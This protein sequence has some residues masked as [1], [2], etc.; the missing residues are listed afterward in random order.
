MRQFIW[1]V[2]ARKKLLRKESKQ[3]QEQRQRIGRQLELLQQEDP[4]AVED[5]KDQ[6][7]VLQVLVEK[8]KD[9]ADVLIRETQYQQALLKQG[10]TTAIDEARP[11]RHLSW[12]TSLQEMTPDQ[13]P[14]ALDLLRTASP[15]F[16][17]R[18]KELKLRQQAIKSS[19]ALRNRLDEYTPGALPHPPSLLAFPISGTD[20]NGANVSSA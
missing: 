20:G 6:E 13:R 10:A 7:L 14:L 8:A 5:P 16:K 19:E 2:T 15:T 3:L 1:S 9:K 4:L 12:I 11:Y 18:Q 17:A